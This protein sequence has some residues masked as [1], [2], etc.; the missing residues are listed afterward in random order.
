MTVRR[1][2]VGRFGGLAGGILLGLMLGLRRRS[3][4]VHTK[5]RPMGRCRHRWISLSK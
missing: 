5:L 1:G 3:R 2:C 4:M